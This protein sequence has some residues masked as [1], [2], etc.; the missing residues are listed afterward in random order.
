[1]IKFTNIDNTY[2][3]KSHYKMSF[4]ISYLCKTAFTLVNFSAQALKRF[5]NRVSG[6][7]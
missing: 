2:F 3:D 7:I 4:N 6:K 1:M 5:H